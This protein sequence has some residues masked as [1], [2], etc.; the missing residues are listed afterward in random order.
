MGL[1][2]FAGELGMLI[3]GKEDTKMGC[4]V[5]PL[6]LRTVLYRVGCVVKQCDAGS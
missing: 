2:G 3:L 5:V 1:K 6:W 4:L